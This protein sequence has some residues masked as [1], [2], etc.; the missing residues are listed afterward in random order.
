MS[1]GWYVPRRR[2]RAQKPV[3]ELKGR[4]D[5]DVDDSVPAP[6]EVPAPSA[7]DAETDDEVA[8]TDDEA[9]APDDG[10]FIFPRIPDSDDV[11]EWETFFS[12]DTWK[13]TQEFMNKM[14]DRFKW[15]PYKRRIRSAVCILYTWYAVKK[16]SAMTKNDVFATLQ[17]L[18]METCRYSLT[19][20]RVFFSWCDKAIKFSRLMVMYPH[21]ARYHARSPTETAMFKHLLA[22]VEASK[23]SFIEPLA[24]AAEPVN[25]V[26]YSRVRADIEAVRTEMRAKIAALSQ[27]GVTLREEIAA[28]KLDREEDIVAFKRSNEMLLDAIDELKAEVAALKRA[29]TAETATTPAPP[30]HPDH[31]GYAVPPYMFPWPPPYPPHGYPLPGLH[32]PPHRE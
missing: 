19:H 3:P 16:K 13:K 29:R 30:T 9:G 27:S 28:R 17:T 32:P 15:A 26:P 31:R 22:V 18:N 11:G 8:E 24:P 5:D 2:R 23:I 12:S 14:D 25:A 6:V 1:K 4:S 21:T 7:E 10:A 20:R